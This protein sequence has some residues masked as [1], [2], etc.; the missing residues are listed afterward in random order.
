MRSAARN[1]CPVIGSVE[2]RDSTSPLAEVRYSGRATR[3]MGNTMSIM[4]F[5][6]CSTS[7]TAS[8]SPPSEILGT[9]A[10]AARPT[11]FARRSS[12]LFV[13]LAVDG[14]GVKLVDDDTDQLAF[15]AAEFGNDVFHAL[16]DVE[17]GRQDGYE[18]VSGFKQ[19]VVG[20]TPGHRRPVEDHQI[21][22]AGGI[23]LRDRLAYGVTRLGIGPLDGRQDRDSVRGP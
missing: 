21:A 7:S 23:R 10:V 15:G 14:R 19:F 16:I 12:I 2:Q 17:A 20:R 6:V 8:R 11:G 1:R 18:A 5:A 13:P 4:K 3:R 22:A 9:L